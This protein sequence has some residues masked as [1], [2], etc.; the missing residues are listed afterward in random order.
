MSTEFV[1]HLFCPVDF[2]VTPALLLKLP[3]YCA[4]QGL[5]NGWASVRPSVRLSV[6]W[7]A[8]RTPLLRVCCC[9]PDGQAISI[10][11]G[12]RR[13]RQQRRRSTALSSTA[14]SSKREQ[15]HVDSWRRR[16]NTDWLLQVIL[17]Q[18]GLRSTTFIVGLS[19]NTRS[20]FGGSKYNEIDFNWTCLRHRPNSNVM[21]LF[22]SNQLWKVT[23]L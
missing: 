18:L 17:I 21:G 4:E 23:A 14:F 7:F 2:P 10:D 1:L 15:C 13:A 11:S 5:R 6:P 12:G 19:T 9:G 20:I 8:R 16:L 3:A 22:Q